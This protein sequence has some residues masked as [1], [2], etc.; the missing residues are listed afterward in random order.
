MYKT[1]LDYPSNFNKEDQKSEVNHLRKTLSK[2]QHSIKESK[3]PVL[4]YID[5]WGQAGKG[6]LLSHIIREL[7]PRF[8]DVIA[9]KEASPEEERHPLLW[10]YIKNIP[11]NGKITFFDTSYVEELV[12][13]RYSHRLTSEELNGYIKEVNTFEKQLLEN[14]YILIKIFLTISEKEAKE[15]NQKLLENRST[16]WK[17]S[18]QD[19]LQTTDRELFED[20]YNHV[21]QATDTKESPWHLVDSKN[22]K[23]AEHLVLSK[24]AQTIETAIQHPE[25]R[26]ESLN[27]SFE[28]VTM[29]KLSSI[30]F[31]KGIPEDEYKERLKILQ[32]KLSSQN[33]KLYK[34][35]IPVMIAYEGWDAAGK[36]GNIKRLTHAFDARGCSVYPIAAPSPEEKERHHLWRFAI[37]APKS[38]HIAIFDRTWYGRVLVERIEGF[39]TENDWKRAFQEINE[40]ERWFTKHGG[41]LIKFWIHIDKNTQLERFH[42]READPDK[43][44]KITDEDWRNRE[45]WEVYETAVD[46]MFEKTS[47]TFAPWHIIESNDKKYAR[48]QT[49]EI[50]TNAIDTY[51]HA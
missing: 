32:N 18:L 8:Y 44:W 5:G 20:Y 30:V 42:S 28:K 41:I 49:L 9:Y 22:R 23:K 47:T 48:L 15:R 21:L 10:R 29:P 6:T 37:R 12:Y 33:D 38:G 19:Q 27:S 40:F 24:I 26:F 50:V 34:K 51:L 11:E 35:G 7:D 25:P 46:E 2:L 31:H 13:K 43:R 4:I 17:V 1:T 14:G 36:G 39:C 45:K 16:K 3:R